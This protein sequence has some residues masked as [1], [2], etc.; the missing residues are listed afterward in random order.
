MKVKKILSM[1]LITILLVNTFSE[2]VFANING[3]VSSGRYLN[4][5]LYDSGNSLLM[6]GN[7]LK[8]D[9]TSN[10]LNLNGTY[11]IDNM[12]GKDVKI[13]YQIDSVRDVISTGVIKEFT[14]DSSN[15]VGTFGSSLVFK[16]DGT[17]QSDNEVCFSDSTSSYQLSVYVVY[18][19]GGEEQVYVYSNQEINVVSSVEE[20]FKVNKDDYVIAPFAGDFE[21]YVNDESI[22]ESISNQTYL[23]EDLYS[24]REFSIEGH[25]KTNSD[26][27][28]KMLISYDI[29]DYNSY[30]NKN[31]NE[32]LIS[33]YSQTEYNKGTYITFNKKFYL[34]TK[35][36]GEIESSNSPINYI[37]LEN[38]S[39][40]IRVTV[41][42]EDG[43][44]K[45]KDFPFNVFE[46]N[47]TADEMEER[48]NVNIQLNKD[49]NDINGD[50]LDFKAVYDGNELKDVELNDLRG[51]FVD[52]DIDGKF[53]SSI[54]AGKDFLI[55]YD[56]TTMN[57]L[58][59][60][61][62]DERILE[63]FTQSE[64]TRENPIEFNRKLRFTVDDRSIHRQTD[65]YFPIIKLHDYPSNYI[66]AVNVYFRNNEN[67]PYR[68]YKRLIKEFNVNGNK[69]DLEF[70]D[71]ESLKPDN[72]TKLDTYIKKY[73]EQDKLESF[74]VLNYLDIKDE[75]AKINIEGLLNNS[76]MSGDKLSVTYDITSY[77]SYMKKSGAKGL[78][79]SYY[80]TNHS[81][82]RNVEFNKNFYITTNDRE[83]KSSDVV[84]NTVY[85]DTDTRYYTLKVVV[86]N[87]TT[88]EVVI[89]RDFTFLMDSGGQGKDD[90]IKP[91]VT[92]PDD[93]SAYFIDDEGKYVETYEITSRRL[94]ATEG[95]VK[96]DLSGFL[97]N[98][99]SDSEVKIDYNLVAED[100]YIS[101]INNSEGELVTL[102][103]DPNNRTFS[104]YPI[105]NSMQEWLGKDQQDGFIK[106]Y[107]QESYISN[108]SENYSKTF[109][110]NTKL[111]KDKPTVKGD[112]SMLVLDTVARNYV[113]T[114][115]ASNVTTG[116]VIEKSANL[117]VTTETGLEN[118][119][120]KFDSPVSVVSPRR[121][122]GYFVDELIPLSW[123]AAED[124]E[125]EMIYYKIYYY[126]STLDDTTSTGEIVNYMK[127]YEDMPKVGDIL[128]TYHP[129]ETT[130]KL[131]PV[132]I[133]IHACD[134][135]HVCSESTRS[136]PFKINEFGIS[137]GGGDGGNGVAIPIDI[138]INPAPTDVWYNKDLDISVFMNGDSE[139][140]RTARKRYD[141]TQ[142]P[143]ISPILSKT[144]PA[145]GLL[146]IS[147]S[148]I[149]YV[150]A[151]IELEDGTK[152]SKTSG[153]YKIDKGDLPG[154]EAKLI[155]EDGSNHNDWVKGDVTLQANLIGSSLSGSDIEYMVGGHHTE[156]QL[157]KSGA[158][159]N[160]EGSN[161][162]FVR[163]KDNSGKISNTSELKLKIDKSESVVES[164]GIISDK[165]GKYRI[166]TR[167][168]DNLSGV[169]SVK[170]NTGE[171]LH[172]TNSTTR[173]YELRDVESRPISLSVI[174]NAGNVSKAHLFLEDIEI[175]GLPDGDKTVRDD[176]NFSFNG[177]KAKDSGGNDVDT[178]LSYRLGNKDTIC[179]ESPC[180]V[181]L[182][183][184]TDVVL[185]SN[186]GYRYSKTSWKVGTIDKSKLRLLLSG[187][188]NKEGD[189]V[190]FKWNHEITNG[191]LSCTPNISSGSISGIKY[192]VN[193][194]SSQNNTLKC[195]LKAEL[196]GE[197]IESNTVIIYPDYSKEITPSFGTGF[198]VKLL[199]EEDRL[200]TTYFLNT[201]KGVIVDDEEDMDF[202]PEIIFE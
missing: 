22:D 172:L 127:I 93:L 97:K 111:D 110:L 158:V 121:G 1:L 202:L 77:E 71:E 124:K 78:L 96:L 67:E 34:K 13:Y 43:L 142:S 185:S 148:G 68:Y 117:H 183:R 147:E 50:G 180:E 14:I 102:L 171:V 176:I 168:S 83:D 99:W 82:L 191:D 46:N 2:N 175:V 163:V 126:Y 167:I 100:N 139:L 65:E 198:S 194:D 166:E 31:Y 16:K 146:K 155:N 200:G 193:I 4:F 84:G 170:L 76:E 188:R 174:D 53:L 75:P 38:R 90:I 182:D 54:P 120:P 85:L 23:F 189:K 201:S 95:G 195:K 36:E 109:T 70:I 152:I 113:L 51:N 125:D 150:H 138:S 79:K 66:L 15:E 5:G 143:I 48:A 86:K 112:D 72:P 137:E 64:Y 35:A 141:I 20:P 165:D 192:D 136:N 29:I 132:Y 74:K 156:W 12:V 177:G 159:L 21:A 80:Q 164:L 19:S 26:K 27:V 55:M 190:Q 118:T 61:E 24:P 98:S 135:N 173:L 134:I 129:V 104:D 115:K 149:Y 8:K 25:L 33:S 116:E 17:C 161:T 41:K 44:T 39:Y 130:T 73:N 45:I 133:K 157:Y 153:P 6:D 56:I 52:V 40:V 92:I 162:V 108:K 42:S 62:E 87:E 131:E 91:D 9:E 58:K 18:D 105:V 140:L 3:E 187:E 28:Q 103:K 89:Q 47:L 179:T 49:L 123:I 119:S 160:T 94:N 145:N 122:T 37:P 101:Y 107:N 69:Q 59:Y 32:G 199:R 81:R 7:V 181:T 30:L 11:E 184:N 88:G 128:S 106:R 114:V 186:Y 197:S 63:S 151:Q 144:L 60:I 57:D 196:F 169:S 154:Y 10:T 178:N